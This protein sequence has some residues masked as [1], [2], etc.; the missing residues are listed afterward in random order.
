MIR[1]A[2][3]GA[4]ALA[5]L[6]TGAAP[7]A[8][9]CSNPGRPPEPGVYF[10]D[11]A[12]AGLESL[13]PPLRERSLGILNGS[14]CLCGC[15]HTL[16]SCRVEEPRCERSR[17]LASEVTQRLAS[18]GTDAE[19]QAFL[20]SQP[21][22]P[23]ALATPAPQ[24]PG[25]P[26]APAGMGSVLDARVFDIPI[27]GA[28]SRGPVDAP[29]TLV[30]FSDFQ[31]PFCARSLPLIEQTL[32]S[33]PSQVR[34]VFKHFPIP[35]HSLAHDAAMA[36]LAA[37]EQDRFWPMHDLLFANRSELE[38]PGLMRMAR[39]LGLD[40]QRF[41]RDLDSVELQDRLRKD[42]DAGRVAE[43]TGTPMFYLNGRKVRILSTTGLRQA[44]EE[45]LRIP[46]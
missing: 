41:E 36:A 6:A 16:A 19:V 9:Q 28:P 7:A 2:A 25:P 38:R 42:M 22:L 26:P 12:G 33:F 3:L 20:R 5:A 11:L 10:R 46:F 21:I 32:N 40:L 4:A 43:I 34:L 29:V 24:P 15:R 23:R 37:Q 17:R 13:P 35:S 27:A 14:P 39:S 1:T 30:M 18:G 8:A 44:I 45:A 31:C